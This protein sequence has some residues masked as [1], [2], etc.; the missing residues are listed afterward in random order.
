MGPSP[1]KT[2]LGATLGGAFTGVLHN[3][4]L[5]GNNPHGPLNPHNPLLSVG[6]HFEWLA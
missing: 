4:P 1:V 5:G 3:I 2:S 6:S